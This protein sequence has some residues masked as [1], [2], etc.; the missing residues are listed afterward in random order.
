MLQNTEQSGLH[1]LSAQ[2]KEKEKT[3]LSALA[4]PEFTLLI[5]RRSSNS[6]NKSI[7]KQLGLC[8]LELH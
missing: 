8:I 3:L 2:T 1:P 6:G 4:G 5:S 7:G